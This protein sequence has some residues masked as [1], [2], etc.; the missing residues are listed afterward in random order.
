MPYVARLHPV[1]PKVDPLDRLVHLEK[2]LTSLTG[3]KERAVVTH[4]D[5]ARTESP[6]VLTLRARVDSLYEQT[7][8]DRSN[9]PV[10]RAPGHE[11]CSTCWVVERT[12]RRQVNAC[13]TRPTRY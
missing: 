13:T 5:L 9:G 11:Q 12:D 7:L 8:A 2:E 1:Q 4:T 6:C 10:V 3:P